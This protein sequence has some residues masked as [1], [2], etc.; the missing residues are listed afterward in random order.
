MKRNFFGNA[1]LQPGDDIAAI[2][3]DEFGDFIDVFARF[4]ESDLNSD[5]EEMWVCVLADNEEHELGVQD[6]PTEEALRKWLS[7]QR[8]EISE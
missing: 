1:I 4:I 5:N 6:F 7:D 2:W 3:S 8:I